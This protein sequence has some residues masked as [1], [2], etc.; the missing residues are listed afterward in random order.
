MGAGFAVGIG[1]K[2][3]S[4]YSAPVGGP[5]PPLRIEAASHLRH[6]RRVRERFPD[7]IDLQIKRAGEL[8]ELCVGRGASIHRTI[9][10]RYSLTARWRDKVKSEKLHHVLP[11]DSSQNQSILTQVT[12]VN[13]FHLQPTRPEGLQQLV[14]L[15][16]GKDAKE[17]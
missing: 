15:G 16:W 14:G 17:Y 1:R 10:I 4:T 2:P 11:R 6:L 9:K 7:H 13:L 12:A 8:A 3:L 5:L